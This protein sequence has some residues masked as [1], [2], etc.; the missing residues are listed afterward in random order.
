M[1]CAS[2]LSFG[3]HINT[4]IVGKGYDEDLLPLIANQDIDSLPS[5][6]ASILRVSRTRT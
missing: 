4:H 5:R 1:P 2:R 3:V 6:M